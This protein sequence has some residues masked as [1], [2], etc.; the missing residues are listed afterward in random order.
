ME[1]LEKR[2]H[3]A[4]RVQHSITVLTANG[5]LIVMG[6]FPDKQ[7][8]QATAHVNEKRWDQAADMF[9]E[10]PVVTEGEVLAFVT[11]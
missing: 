11:L 7:A 6:Y 1:E 4:P 8:C 9:E 5:E 3:E 10:P 2:L